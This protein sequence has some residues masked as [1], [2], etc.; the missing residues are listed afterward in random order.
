MGWYGD[1][2]NRSEKIKSLTNSSDKNMCL[3][4]CYRG[5]NFRGVLWAVWSNESGIFITCDIL[6]YRSGMWWNK[7]LCEKME[8]F[9]YSCPLSYLNMTPT[10]SEE[11]RKKVRE[12]HELRSK[13]VSTTT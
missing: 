7:P 12:Y 3:K 2:I 1:Y 11:W 10:I 9:Y 6:E 4:H 13:K 8:P 5:G